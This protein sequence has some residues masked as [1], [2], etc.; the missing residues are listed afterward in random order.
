MKVALPVW[1]HRISPVFDTAQNLII[2]T[3]LEN[4]QE[5][6]RS[7]YKLPEESYQKV[8][9]LVNYEVNT[10]I[11]GAIS[12]ALA[13]FILSLNIEVIAWITG[14]LENVLKA[15]Q[16]G[17]L[18]AQSFMMPGCHHRCRQRRCKRKS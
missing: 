8:K 7:L 11:C 17:K 14:D 13:T 3:L 12:K 15:F 18:P 1:E 4:K 16:S 2:V 10:L 6:T 9:S 5:S